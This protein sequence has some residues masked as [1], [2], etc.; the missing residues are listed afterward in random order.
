[1]TWNQPCLEGCSMLLLQHSF[2][3]RFKTTLT[4]LFALLVRQPW[5]KLDYWSKSM[6]W[7]LSTSWRNL[8]IMAFATDRFDFCFKSTWNDS[9]I[10]IVYW[11]LSHSIWDMVGLTHQANF[12]FVFGGI[13]ELMKKLALSWLILKRHQST[14]IYLQMTMESQISILRELINPNVFLLISSVEIFNV[15]HVR[16]LTSVALNSWSIFFNFAGSKHMGVNSCC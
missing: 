1:M 2:L 6:H 7:S 13:F 9:K 8:L 3:S 16:N 4:T 12:L 14:G 11:T 10:S 15:L 5:W